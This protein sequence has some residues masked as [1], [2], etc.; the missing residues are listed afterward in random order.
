M[1]VRV[2]R[3]IARLNVGGPAR[4]CLLLGPALARRGFEQVLATGDLDAGEACAL[5]REPWLGAGSRIARIP[6]L[7]RRISV[8]DDARALAA[9]VGLL[10]RERPLVV[11][12]HTAKAGAL[13]R[14]AARIAGVPVVVHTFH[15][16]VLSGYFG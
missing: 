10:R 12:T 2:V 3:I 7:G 15:G 8:R 5:E 4:H 1:G 13:G 16:H 14:I 9:L 11:H 6:G